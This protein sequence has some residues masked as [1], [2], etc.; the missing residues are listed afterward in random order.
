M[1]EHY[2]ATV[3]VS[4][5]NDQVILDPIDL[6]F[7]QIDDPVQTWRLDLDSAAPRCAVFSIQPASSSS[8]IVQARSRPSGGVWLDWNQQDDGWYSPPFDDGDSFMLEVHV[9]QGDAIRHGSLHFEVR[10]TGGGDDL[11]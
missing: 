1:T 6:Q 10:D 3:N 2:T 4:M 11:T 7:E 8:H 9:V 5:E